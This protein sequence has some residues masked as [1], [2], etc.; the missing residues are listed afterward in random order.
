[1]ADKLTVMTINAAK[2]RDKIYRLFDGGG[3]HIE[4]HPNG[5]KYWRL[6]YLINGKEKRAGL[7][8]WPEIGLAVARQKRAEYR[9][10]V[11]AGSDPID[12]KRQA[13]AR[14]IQ[15]NANTFERIAREWHEKQAIA[16]SEKHHAKVMSSLES[17]VFPKIGN[18]PISEITPPELLR[19]LRIIET[20]G[21]LEIAGRV[22]QRCSAVFRY[23]VA[24]G[25]ADNDPALALKGSLKTPT[26]THFAALGRGEIGGLLRDISAYDGSAQTRLAMRLLALTFV[27]TVELR[28]ARWNEFELDDETPCWNVPA[29]RMKTRK[30]HWVPLS[31]QALEVLQQIREINGDRELLF[32]NERKPDQ[33]MSENT[34]LF[35]LYRMGYHSRMT[36]HGFRACASTVLNECGF[37]PDVIERQLAHTERNKVRA[38]YNRAE[39]RADR[40]TMMQAWADLLDQMEKGTKV[41]PIRGKAA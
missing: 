25:R 29:E 6:K 17:Q 13:K 14:A 9:E 32:P 40:A 23:A 31:T 41:T 36:G 35:A 20:R 27:R 30:L 28:G 15:D 2:S 37:K 10:H 24:T 39:Y 4:V 38:A 18:R 21:A 33:P 3:L 22:R 12:E 19:V 1:M 34:I 11:R 16:W 8:V 5:A 26:I 7:G